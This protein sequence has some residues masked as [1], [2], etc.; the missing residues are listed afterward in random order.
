MLCVTFNYF[1][2]HVK[3]LPKWHINVK[4]QMW[5]FF[6]KS[7]TRGNKKYHLMKTCNSSTIFASLLSFWPSIPHKDTRN[8][9]TSITGYLINY[10]YNSEVNYF[11]ILEDNIN[12]PDLLLCNTLYTTHLGHFQHSSRRVLTC[13]KGSREQW[14]QATRLWT[15]PDVSHVGSLLQSHS[16]LQ[17]PPAL[18]P[19]VPAC[20]CHL[21]KSPQVW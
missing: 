3:H 9:V 15:C 17:T 13:G 4:F 18:S 6:F 7:L 1:L 10:F 2:A 12:K 16:Q 11:K 14:H 5:Q 19:S 21:H 20:C 8:A